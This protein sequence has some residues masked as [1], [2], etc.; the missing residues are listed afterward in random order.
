MASLAALGAVGTVLPIVKPV[1]GEGY[2]VGKNVIKETSNI[3]RN[4]LVSLAFG[5]FAS[6]LPINPINIII[7]LILSFI[8]YYINPKFLRGKS[9]DE[10]EPDD[11]NS[12]IPFS[13][14]ILFA[15]IPY[16][17]ITIPLYSLSFNAIS[18]ILSKI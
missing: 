1:I 4:P 11:E 9:N 16:F 8:I 12:R 10:D 6:L 3:G 15:L 17:L 2:T 7:L 5:I 18:R 14:S 13:R